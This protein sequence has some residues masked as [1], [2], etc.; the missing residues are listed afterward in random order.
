MFAILGCLACKHHWRQQPRLIKICASKE[1]E[2]SFVKPTWSISHKSSLFFLGSC[3][4]ETLSSFLMQKKFNVLVNHNFG[5]TFNPISLAEALRQATNPAIFNEQMIFQDH[6]DSSLYHSWHHHGSYSQ[7]DRQALV[8]VIK[9]TNQEAHEHL[10]D[11]NALYITFGTSFVH[12][13]ASDPTIIVNNCH[14]QPSS[15]FHKRLLKVDE[16]VQKY[17]GVIEGVLSINPTLQ[18][19]I[20]VSPVRHTRG[21]HSS[22]FY[23]SSLL[24]TS[25]SA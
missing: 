24:L 13:L 15:L 10:I 3:F 1:T 18:I 8:D 2:L 19:V 14:K 20:T 5:I 23:L 11:C 12:E 22:F 9:R 21:N 4:S 17:K 16:I 7:L 25:F 6:L